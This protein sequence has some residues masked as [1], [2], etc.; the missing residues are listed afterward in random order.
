MS[1]VEPG[2]TD[3][4]WLRYVWTGV[5]LG[6]LTGVIFAIYFHATSRSSSNGI[7]VGLT[8]AGVVLNL[9]FGFVAS[10]LTTR[11]HRL[12]A[13][14]LGLIAVM[15]VLTASTYLDGGYTSPLAVILAAPVAYAALACT[16]G[17]VGLL[18]TWVVGVEII[19]MVFDG[20]VE[21]PQQVMGAVAVGLL[22]A[23]SVSAASTRGRYE[24]L[25]SDLVGRLT[26]QAGLDGLTGIPN[27]RSFDEKLE[28]EAGRFRRNRSPFLLATFDLD[29]FKD[30][31]DRFGHAAGDELLCGVARS[32]RGSLRATDFLA[33]SG[34]DEFSVICPDTCDADSVTNAIRKAV[35]AADP[36]GMVTA[37][38]GI[39]TFTDPSETVDGLAARA[40]QAMYLDKTRKPTSKATLQP[41]DP[42]AIDRADPV[43]R[44]EGARELG[45]PTAQN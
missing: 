14:R 40:D 43:G 38:V 18:A 31:N 8:F 11:M 23:L 37:S 32:V 16:T 24:A 39:A 20:D 28:T 10:R 4:F 5:G 35:A 22:C 17:F 21:S 44:A 2:T 19:S 26:E 15:V 7:L 42:R 1:R 13:R 9:G 27:R 6:T 30:V 29:H 45:L 12:V 33:R 36:R 25:L 41:G 34:G 3:G